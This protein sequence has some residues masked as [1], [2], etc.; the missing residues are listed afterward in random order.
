MPDNHNR[1]WSWMPAFIRR[2]QQAF[3][4][5]HEA[6]TEYESDYRQ[7]GISGESHD[8]AVGM[9]V[10]MKN[11][12][13]RAGVILLHGYM[14]APA[15]M[16]ELARHLN[17]QGWWVYIPRIKGHG[18][19][20][21][22]LAIRTV[23]DWRASVDTGYDLIRHACH[24]VI[25]CGFSTGAA[26]ALDLA[27]RIPAPRIQ[28]VVAISPPIKLKSQ[29][30]RLA[31]AIGMWNQITTR[32]HL[33]E[34]QKKFIENHPENP[35]INY[36]RNPIS[37][38]IELDR[39][40]KS[41]EPRLK[42]IAIPTLIIQ[43]SEDPVVDEKGS[44]QAFYTIGANQKIYIMVNSTRHSIV[45]GEAARPVHAMISHFIQRNLF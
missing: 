39:L 13:S 9:P 35:H 19:S 16:V 14:A 38:V 3:R 25:V 32:F 12:R 33:T 34:A 21:E 20:P 8:T 2:R 36:R 26:L 28:A 45:L 42:D 11:W 41:L 24:N 43:G 40:I 5:Y 1:L 27:V 30:A 29:T 4:R 17:K 6:C 44:R 23:E 37:G 22:D 15:E 18:T 10:L 7:F 31:P